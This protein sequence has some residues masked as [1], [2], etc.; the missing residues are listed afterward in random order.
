MI[1]FFIFCFMCRRPCDLPLPDIFWHRCDTYEIFLELLQALHCS[2]AFLWDAQNHT[3]VFFSFV[4]HFAVLLRSHTQTK[5]T[6]FTKFDSS[7]CIT[8]K[9]VKKY[10]LHNLNKQLLEFYA[11]GSLICR[12][13][14]G[15]VIYSVIRV[16]ERQYRQC[17]WK[18]FMDR[19]GLLPNAVNTVFK[20]FSFLLR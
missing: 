2:S 13:L 4:H 14:R 12:H 17:R 15:A 11:W 9:T 18:L 19:E 5:E 3:V 10:F 20:L 16:W 6:K 8:P 1:Y 7:S